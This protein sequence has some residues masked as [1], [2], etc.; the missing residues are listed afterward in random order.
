MVY[1]IQHGRNGSKLGTALSKLC[2]R[3]CFFWLIDW[4]F[5]VLL[6]YYECYFNWL[7]LL[8][9]VSF[10]FKKD[11]VFLT[12]REKNAKSVNMLCKENVWKGYNILWWISFNMQINLYFYFFF[13]LWLY[14]GVPMANTRPVNAII[15]EERTLEFYFEECELFPKG[16]LFCLFI[17]PSR[18][19]ID[20]KVVV[21]LG[22]WNIS[23]IVKSSSTSFTDAGA[24]LSD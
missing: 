16:L 7:S 18:L 4:L 24:L 10:V 23:W 1:S 12:Q 19:L 8:R 15:S 22:K 9:D 2:L 13:L 21:M 11:V 6:F 5:F 20:W 14:S 3:F 17:F